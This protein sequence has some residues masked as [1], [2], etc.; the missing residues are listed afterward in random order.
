M[1]E[2]RNWSSFHVF[3]SDP[4]QTER[5][6][7][8][9]VGPLAKQTLSSGAAARWFFV[10]YWDGGPHVR[11]RFLDLV[12][13]ADVFD[14]LTEAASRY[15]IDNPVTAEQY[16]SGHGFDGQPV[17]VAELEWYG[18]GAV[19]RLDYEPENGRY[20][21]VGAMVENETLFNASSDLAVALLKSTTGQEDF[22]K[23]IS[24]SL[25]LMV[26]SVFAFRT[27]MATLA[28][29]FSNYGKFWEGYPGTAE[30]REAM[31]AAPDGK[32]RD[33]VRQLMQQ[34][35]DD[36]G[37]AMQRI[38]VAKI[39][40]AVTRFR[41]LYEAGELLSPMTG[42]PASSESEYDTAVL[43][44]IGS[45]IHMLNNR[46]AIAPPLEYH[47]AATITAATATEVSA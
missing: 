42:K 10:R 43:S 13:E 3:L 7:T 2:S 1:N 28:Q 46:L 35:E 22:Q 25:I 18:E 21:G 41:Q 39:R 26:M 23:R 44:M 36:T 20:G 34:A 45:Q 24:M 38:W 9:C 29:F 33:R 17:D 5:F 47:L 27:S 16:Y 11:I 31:A 19:V 8:E 15:T 12:D 14:S 30:I 37:S 32:L 6:I 4:G 40:H